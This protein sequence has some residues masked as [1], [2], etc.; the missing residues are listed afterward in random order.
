M[1]G[2]G[3]LVRPRIKGLIGDFILADGTRHVNLIVVVNERLEKGDVTGIA[4][5][6]DTVAII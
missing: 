5:G 1:S 4:F 6:I 3:M 2:V